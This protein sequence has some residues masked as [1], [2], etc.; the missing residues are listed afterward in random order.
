MK[1]QIYKSYYL[2]RVFFILI[3][4][5][6]ITFVLPIGIYFEASSQ[7]V[8]AQTI[9]GIVFCLSG[10]T[11]LI[12]TKYPNE[13]KY[14]ETMSIPAR[15]FRR[16]HFSNTSLLTT[17]DDDKVYAWTITKISNKQFEKLWANEGNITIKKFYNRNKELVSVS[18]TSLYS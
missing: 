5:F 13:I 3:L 6:G 8:W 12:G 7:N 16:Q 15:C 4:L 1:L 18:L 9:L 2:T 10:I 14:F 17:L 11:G